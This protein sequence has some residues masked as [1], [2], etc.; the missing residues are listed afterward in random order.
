MLTRDE[1]QSLLED[2][3]IIVRNSGEIPEIALH[4]S[5]YYLTR[6]REGPLL[7]LTGEEKEKLYDAAEYRYREIVLR[8]IDPR[9]RD[10][11]IYRGVARTITNWHRYRSFCGRINRDCSDFKSVVAQKLLEFLDREYEDV[12]A[13]LRTSSINCSREQ[14]DGFLPA[15]GVER[16]DLPSDWQQ[17]IC[18]NK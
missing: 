11:G 10:L 18:P 3:L 15:L 7:E 1:R 4:S 8:D 13:G 16:I 12:V 14:L 2:E 6:D 17:V 5:L 9:N